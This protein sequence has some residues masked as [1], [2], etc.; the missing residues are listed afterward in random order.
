MLP[1]DARFALCR[2]KRELLGGGRTLGGLCVGVLLL[3]SSGCAVPQPRGE[4]RLEN[5]I[6]PTSNRRYLL[7]LPKEYVESDEPARAAR[8]WPLVV[9]FHGMKP[10][11]IAYYQAREW[12][13]E[14]DRYGY[15]VIAPVLRAFDFFFGQF[16]QRTVTT[17]FK[18]DE[19]AILAILDHVFETTKADPS[20]VLS[21]G[22]SSGGYM[23]HYMI[24]RHPE[25]FTCLAPRQANFSA[26]ILDARAV[27]R[28][29]DHPI[30]L[31][32][33]MND[34]GICKRETKEA[35]A[36]YENHD[37]TNLAWVFINRL[38]HERTPD[39]AAYFFASICGAQ[40][41]T[42]PKVLVKRQ[43][44]DGNT[45]GLSLLAGNFTRQEPDNEPPVAG[46]APRAD[47]TTRRP[48]PR[49]PR[50]TAAT[51]PD[52]R[53]GDTVAAEKPRRKPTRRRGPTPSR[54]VN[55]G[56]PV[57]ISVSSAIGFEPLVLVYSARCP[58]DWHRTAEFFWTL[59]GQRIGTGVNGQKTISAPGD[60]SLEL[61][62]VTRDGREHRAA[63][64]VRVLKN[65]EAS[66]LRMS[67]DPGEASRA[68]TRTQ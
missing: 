36:W 66:A 24:N 16:P 42:E 48:T 64:Q 29:R 13:Q 19:E 41:N 51:P 37:Y 27:E 34:L 49:R 32:T 7:Y 26:S 1:A 17:A 23:A 68:A 2:Q 46:G 38:G 9:T 8:R 31:L 20:N 15:I 30:L 44:I 35:I 67:Q 18:S 59:N 4:G 3:L 40:P 5:R 10:Y 60:Y 55:Q 52:T 50:L 54:P 28:S 25:R 58:T 63:H 65:I 53:P 47:V 11:D 6:E 21:T 14:A 61:L 43:A 57:S 33:T 45:S 22:F 12:Q 56:N 39:L 62:I